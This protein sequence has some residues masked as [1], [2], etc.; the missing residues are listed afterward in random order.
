M[1]GCDQ[2]VIFGSGE[3]IGLEFAPSGLP[4][5][6]AGWKRD[7]LFFADGFSKDMD[8]YAAH[9]DTVEPLPFHVMSRY[10]PFAT[11]EYSVE[12]N[13]LNYMLDTNA[14]HVSGRLTTT[15][16]FEFHARKHAEE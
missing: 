4:A 8:F 3:E 7:Y 14:R 12:D 1:T 2:F 10:S 13:D 11:Q 6:P 5:L 16:R 15:Y 9:G